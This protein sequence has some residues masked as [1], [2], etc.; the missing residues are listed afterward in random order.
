MDYS[1]LQKV[2]STANP[3]STSKT[4][5]TPSNTQPA[6]PSTDTSWTIDGFAPLP[7]IAALNIDTVTA[8]TTYVDAAAAETSGT[9]I[10]GS[11]T[12]TAA[13]QT[14]SA[15]ASSA[16]EASQGL[17]TGAIAGIAVGGAIIGI[18]AIVGAVFFARRRKVRLAA[19]RH[20]EKGPG[21]QSAYNE[22]NGKPELQ[23]TSVGRFA[24]P[25]QELDGRAT[26]GF[27]GQEYASR[28]AVPVEI[29]TRPR[30]AATY[31][32]EGSVPTSYYDK[33]G[34]SGYSTTTGEG[35]RR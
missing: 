25:K 24:G 29:D 4:D 3:I 33:M 16:T 1:N 17:G 30:N 20:Q 34:S 2:F 23:G 11:R 12:G 27:H 7:T 5:Y 19:A 13:G 10:T 14:S 6:C 28:N 26:G 32:V 21:S 15:S 8:R 9:S 22:T 35:S 31:E 18:A